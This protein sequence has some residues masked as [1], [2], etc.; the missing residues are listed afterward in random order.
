MKN[1]SHTKHKLA[2]YIFSDLVPE[3]IQ[4]I[5]TRIKENPDL[6]ES[7]HLQTQ[8]KDYLQAKIQLEDMR[9]DPDLDEAERLAETGVLAEFPEEATR[10][11]KWLRYIPA[12]AA[13]IAILMV[14]RIW[15]PNNPDRLFQTYY[16]PLDA[17]DYS[18]RSETVNQYPR[19]TPG[20]QLYNNRDYDQSLLHFDKLNTEMGGLAEIQ[21]FQALN[22][23]G[24]EQYENASG[25]LVS[26][27]DNQ[28]RYLPEALWYLT[29]CY[30]KTGE[31][32]KA[33]DSVSGLKAYGG[34]YGE[35]ARQL[36]RKLR[37]IRK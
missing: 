4:E 24:L 32:M 6:S 23:M 35:Q 8:V 2:D 33:L 14:V 22:Y 18:Q 34:Q 1:N 28:I 5:E 20:I 29:L 12:V 16:Q 27:V 31:Y 19:L 17:A 7:Y 11:R 36:E 37:R 3:E 25:A 21:L 30:V 15:V 10:S 9:L 26:Y 13:A